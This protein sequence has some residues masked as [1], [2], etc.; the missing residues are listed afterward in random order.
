[1]STSNHRGPWPGD[2]PLSR[3]PSDV[4]VC[5]TVRL[6]SAELTLDQVARLTQG[7]VVELDRFVDDPVDL[8]LNG[9]L[10]ARGE[11]IMYALA[12]RG[13]GLV[14]EFGAKGLI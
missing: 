9:Q 4:E 11:V 14:V 13:L 6:G 1:M 5:L 8:L 12:Q 7:Q 10:V 3:G 2:T